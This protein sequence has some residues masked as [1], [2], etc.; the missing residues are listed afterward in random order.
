MAAVYCRWAAHWVHCAHACLVALDYRTIDHYWRIRYAATSYMSLSILLHF[1]WGIFCL[2]LR[3]RRWMWPSF[4][5]SVI[6]RSLVCAVPLYLHTILCENIRS[7]DDEQ[8]PGIYQYR[9]VARPWIDVGVI[10]F[11]SSRSFLW[12]WVPFHV[13]AYTRA[14]NPAQLPTHALT[15]FL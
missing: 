14:H 6:N 5:Y 4:R 3:W 15:I 13:N 10:H 1:I 2:A 11:L 9:F 8:S 7:T 12:T